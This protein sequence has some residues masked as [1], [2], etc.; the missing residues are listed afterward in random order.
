MSIAARDAIDEAIAGAAAPTP[1][2]GPAM[3]QFGLQLSTRRPAALMVPSDI[4]DMEWLSL[5]SGLLQIGDTLRAAR[6][7]ASPIL[8]APALPGLRR[9]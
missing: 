1:A 3:S 4:T 7:P 2:A 5:I 9:R 6:T 8:R